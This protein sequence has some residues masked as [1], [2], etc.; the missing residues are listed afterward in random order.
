M[1]LRSCPREK[2]VSEL[3]ERGQWPQAS[4]PELRDH[5]RGCRGCSDLALVA[6]AFQRERKQA[7]AAANTGF[8]N[9]SSAGPLW[10]RAQLRRRRAA[11]E[12]IERPLVG[13]QIFALAVCLAAALGF[14]GFEARNGIAW[15][16]WLEGLPQTA[17]VQFADLSSSSLLSSGRTWLLLAAAATL[18]LLS[19]VVVY[20]ASEK[21]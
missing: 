3:I 21:R 15:L 11:V 9:A 13:A 19:G 12:R 7:L 18:A 16:S 17:A 5:V 6:A 10:W 4:L 20:L 1:T 14:A 8:A 2:E